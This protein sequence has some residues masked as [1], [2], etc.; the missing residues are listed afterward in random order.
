MDYIETIEKLN[1]NI[2]LTSFELIL[3]HKACANCGVDLFFEETVE[4]NPTFNEAYYCTGGL[5]LNPSFYKFVPHPE[6]EEKLKTKFQSE[7]ENDIVHHN[8]GIAEKFKENL[9]NRI[10]FDDHSADLNLVNDLNV[11][12]IKKWRIDDEFGFIIRGPSGSGKSY[13]ACALAKKIIESICKQIASEK[14]RK[15]DQI[16]VEND[17]GGKIIFIKAHKLFQACVTGDVFKMPNKFKSVSYL[18]IDDL[19]TENLSEFKLECLYDLLDHRFTRK[20]P[21]FITTNLSLNQIRERF[22]ERIS[23]RILGM[24]VPIELTGSD[25]RIDQTKK[26][27]ETLKNRI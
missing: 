24:C 8:I 1:Q 18:F 22:F 14:E 25:R 11:N 13:V 17:F 3:K 15:L 6:C 23:S 16:F 20:L 21:T 4:E 12:L 19:G 2:K 5:Y 27:I 10:D 9:I 26:M 7:Y